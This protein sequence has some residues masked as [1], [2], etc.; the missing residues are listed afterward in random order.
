MENEK[1]YHNRYE[2]F[3]AENYDNLAKYADLN[4]NEVS[5]SMSKIIA[6][7]L[8]AKT[9]VKI[10][11]VALNIARAFIQFSI[12]FEKKSEIADP[13]YKNHAGVASAHIY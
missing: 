4:D 3:L 6:R 1:F 7:H 11:S 2:K 9:D 5:K 13:E 12:D 10:P 8:I